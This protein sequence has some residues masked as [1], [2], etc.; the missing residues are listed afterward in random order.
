MADSKRGKFVVSKVTPIT[1]VINKTITE[2]PESD[3][4]FQEE[5]HIIQ[6][7]YKKPEYEKSEVKPGLYILTMTPGGVKQEKTE[8][9]S[10]KLLE[11]VD[12]TAAIIKE[13]K[14]FFAKLDVYREL[15]QP[16]KRGVLAFS[17]PGMGKSTAIS[18]IAVDMLAEDPGTVVFNWPTSAVDAEDV[19]K[20][21]SVQSEFT[22]ECTRMIL[23]IE[24]I[25]GGERD[26][27]SPKAATSGLLNLLDG[28][29]V[30][31]KLP[32]FII[33]TTNH[34]ENLVEALADRPGR[35]DLKI[36]FKAPNETERIALA[37][38]IAKRKLTD[39][40]KEAF[41]SKSAEKFSIAHIKEV[42]IR[43]R[44]H[45]KTIMEVISELA[46]ASKEFKKG[47]EEEKTMGI[48]W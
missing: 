39:E 22:K 10:H 6:F 35:F 23:I 4:C 9:K 12:N 30:T 27:H 28:I 19:S 48:N 31:F 36:E 33:A 32:T 44:L 38:F 25:G 15:E 24:D 46:A 34:P 20:F 5:G 42:I 18:K 43:S 29:D 17:A 26:D 47:Y 3:L 1:E 40:E 8:F 45:D 2:I 13:A 16:M 37:E 21:L 41:K 14:N 11:T 7:E